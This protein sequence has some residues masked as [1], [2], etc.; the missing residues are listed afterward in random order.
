MKLLNLVI[1][2]CI[3]GL[4]SCGNV[5]RNGQ[6]SHADAV[7][8]MK[9][10]PD[11][12]GI[13]AAIDNEFAETAINWKGIYKGILPGGRYSGVHTQLQLNADHTFIMEM[14]DGGSLHAR[15]VRQTGNFR[16]TDT[17][18]IQ[19]DTKEGPAK[20]MVDE[21]RLIELNADGGQVGVDNAGNYALIKIKTQ[22]T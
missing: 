21:N 20:F 8:S 5:N 4:C 11:S 2:C 1:L 3:A 13:N 19:L 18:T 7:S 9:F 22:H 10:A 17:D 14:N 15:Q 6:A 12:N 16:F